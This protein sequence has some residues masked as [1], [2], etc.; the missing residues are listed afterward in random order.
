MILTTQL[1]TIGNMVINRKYVKNES[2]LAKFLTMAE[3]R[4]AVVDNKCKT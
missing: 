3:S 4:Q 2:H 1:F